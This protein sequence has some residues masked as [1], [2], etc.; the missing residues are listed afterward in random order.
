MRVP[1]SPLTM[2]AR[3][4][5]LTRRRPSACSDGDDGDESTATAASDKSKPSAVASAVA[6]GLF[7]RTSSARSVGEES[8]CSVL[9]EYLADGEEGRDEFAYDDG[10]QSRRETDESDGRRDHPTNEEAPRR[11]RQDMERTMESR[12][13][14]G[15]DRPPLAPKPVEKSRKQSARKSKQK[16]GSAKKKPKPESEPTK[17]A[18]KQAKKLDEPVDLSGWSGRIVGLRLPD[19]V[20]PSF[21]AGSKPTA[22]RVD[23][24][25]YLT[26][27]KPKGRKDESTSKAAV[28]AGW[29]PWT[30]I[31][32]YPD[33][34]EPDA[35]SSH[36]VPSISIAETDDRTNV[37][38]W[39]HRTSRGGFDETS[40]PSHVV[41][42]AYLSNS[43]TGERVRVSMKRDPSEDLDGAF[44]RLQLSLQKKLK[45]RPGK[46]QKHSRGEAREEG[47]KVVLYRRR[48][49]PSVATE[50]WTDDDD[51]E[52]E[53]LGLDSFFLSGFWENIA[54]ASCLCG[55]LYTI[56]EVNED[57]I[58]AEEVREKEEAEAEVAAVV[59][60][61]LRAECTRHELLE[62]YDRIADLPSTIDGLLR[63]A[64]RGDFGELALS[65]PTPPVVGEGVRLPHTMPRF[66]LKSWRS[67]VTS[68]AD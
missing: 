30:D 53:G 39:S 12:D 57:L 32:S 63:D 45:V 4:P 26:R 68:K 46:K 23:P 65:V 34:M 2:V 15:R 6:A 33:S 64:S 27:D 13:S 49:A 50:P 5:S 22:R 43:R 24:S 40:N 61:A 59:E 8:A 52:T 47:E 67:L 11:E 42:S 18:T 62:G 16:K 20:E 55:N 35:E 48:D 28:G 10:Q 56:D 21:D 25:R 58:L 41:L 7:R 17:S 44:R 9:T 3:V 54:T 31:A 38:T 51:D 66:A 36:I 37:V 14:A 1:S 60:D 19:L 29:N